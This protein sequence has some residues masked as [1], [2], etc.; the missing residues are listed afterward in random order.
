MRISR[1][2]K[3]QNSD[4]TIT[5]KGNDYVV[6]EI[7]IRRKDCRK[8]RWVGFNTEFD[9][10]WTMSE[11]SQS[12]AVFSIHHLR[13]SASAELKAKSGFKLENGAIK[14]SAEVS[15]EVKIN[16]NTGKAILRV[17]FEISRRHV[18]ATNVGPG[19]SG[20][21]IQSGGVHYN[22]KWNDRFNYYFNHYYTDLTD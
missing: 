6:R 18:L 7:R 11:N 2:S 17:N 12:I 20:S 1:R 8:K 15:G 5:A 22:H 3:T 9:P 10:D 21:T 16:V 13:A 14:P 4:G 19:T